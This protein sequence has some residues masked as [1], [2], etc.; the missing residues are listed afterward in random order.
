MKYAEN[1]DEMVQIS[2]DPTIEIKDAYFVGEGENT[3]MVF[4]YQKKDVEEELDPVANVA[5]AAFVTAYATF[6]SFL[7]FRFMSLFSSYGR[8]ELGELLVKLGRDRVAYY[9]TGTIIIYR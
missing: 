5:L 7:Y 4:T 9:D 2:S 1:Y 3:R 6:L 8:I